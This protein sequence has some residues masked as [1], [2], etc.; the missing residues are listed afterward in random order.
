[1]GNRYCN[2]EEKVLHV[3]EQVPLTRSNLD[4][5]VLMVWQE[6][7]PNI[8]DLSLGYVFNNRKKLG[9]PSTET[10]KRCRRKIVEKRED[11]KGTKEVEE[12]RI[13][14]QKDAIDYALDKV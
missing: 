12:A 1:M 2:A 9:L 6:I 4:I 5:L 8:C 13:N 3:L 11:L 10:I 14:L 7:N